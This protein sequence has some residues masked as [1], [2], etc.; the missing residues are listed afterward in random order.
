MPILIYV[1]I[2]EYSLLC[3]RVRVYIHLGGTRT[4]P[5]R[6]THTPHVHSVL[7]FHRLA[8]RVVLQMQIRTVGGSNLMHEALHRHGDRFAALQFRK[9]LSFLEA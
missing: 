1:C 4:A 8:A 3:I 6:H 7:A 5:M 2:Y 9:V